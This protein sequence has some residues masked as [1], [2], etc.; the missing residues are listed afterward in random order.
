M[1]HWALP[2]PVISS[3]RAP[4][5][6][7]PG[8]AQGHSRRADTPTRRARASNSLPV[9]RPPA[10]RS[11]PRP[12]SRAASSEHCKCRLRLRIRLRCLVRTAR[13]PHTLEQTRAARD[14]SAE[15]RT[16]AMK[17][18]GTRRPTLSRLAGGN[19]ASLCDRRSSSEA[20]R[21]RIRP[22]LSQ[23]SPSR[24]DAVPRCGPS[25]ASLGTQAL[26]AP[27]GWAV[28]CSRP[29]WRPWFP[30]TGT[31]AR[32]HCTRRRKED[33]YVRPE[34][35][36]LG[37]PEVQ[38]HHL[39]ERRT[40]APDHLPESRQPWLRFQHPA[41]VPSLVLS[42]SYGSGGRGPTSDM[43]PRSTFQSCGSSSRLVRRRIRPPR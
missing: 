35:A 34:G 22:T 40:A 2:S 11:W 6:R 43:C 13:L 32:D 3:D 23:K 30:S 15:A 31:L 41:T 38:A 19:G 36:C 29:Q 4:G 37:V 21:S 24:P 9:I 42:S 5:P 33:L 28:T 25:A 39:V 12:A 18:L 14:G 17:V 16:S 20:A 26:T 27:L 7:S 1:S 10:S 8:N